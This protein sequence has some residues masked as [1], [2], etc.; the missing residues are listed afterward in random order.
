MRSLNSIFT[1]DTLETLRNHRGLIILARLLQIGFVVAVLVFL[2][3]KLSSIGWSEVWAALPTNPLYYLFFCLWF[4]AIPV[5]ELWVY[6]LMW[7]FSL[8]RDFAIFL[9]KRVYNLALMSYSGEA[10]LALWAKQNLPLKGRVIFSTIK[11]SNILSGLASNCLTV[12]FLILFLATGQLEGLTSTNPDFGTYLI[13]ATLIG[14]ILVPMVLRFRKSIIALPGHLTRTVFLIHV[15][16]N[17]AMLV[18][19]G[20]TWAVVLPDVPVLTWSLFITAQLVLTRIP[21]LP[22]TDLIYLTLGLT[23]SSYLDAPQATVAGMFLAQGALSQIFNFALYIG[24]S[25]VMFRRNS[26]RRLERSRTAGLITLKQA[27]SKTPLT[28]DKEAS[29]HSGPDAHGLAVATGGAAATDGSAT[30]QGAG[31]SQLGAPPQAV[32]TNERAV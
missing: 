7:G 9:R 25:V 5:A 18:F 19:Q 29:T 24:T 27:N 28:D 23:L 10:F 22:N 14:I 26:A 32:H 3:D 2:S 20:A 21:F 31:A 6:R 12:V 17:L 13:F 4:I 30:M 8:S 1:A 11:D 16:R 15:S